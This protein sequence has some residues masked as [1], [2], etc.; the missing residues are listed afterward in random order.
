MDKLKTKNNLVKESNKVLDVLKN[1]SIYIKRLEKKY[2]ADLSEFTDTI[3]EYRMNL[4]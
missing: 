4:V 1:K 2:K 3:E